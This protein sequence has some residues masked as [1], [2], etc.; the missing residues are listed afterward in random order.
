VRAMLISQLPRDN[1]EIIKECLGKIW[2]G[3]RYYGHRD[4]RTLSQP[5]LNG[6]LE[7]DNLGLR[8]CRW[9]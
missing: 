3:D 8:P 2:G 1:Y 9:S 7:N 5:R 4:G 6:V